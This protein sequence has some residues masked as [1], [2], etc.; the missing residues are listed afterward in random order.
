MKLEN[1]NNLEAVY[2]LQ[3]VERKLKALQNIPGGYEY[4]CAISWTKDAY[5]SPVVEWVD[6]TELMNRVGGVIADYL[7]QEKAKLENKIKEL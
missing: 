7:L 5:S 3:E 2:E 4:S 1:I 6:G